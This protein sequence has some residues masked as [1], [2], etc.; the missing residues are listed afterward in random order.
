MGAG[1]WLEVCSSYQNI[2][3]FSPEL[4]FT[5]FVC[6]ILLIAGP[7]QDSNCDYVSKSDCKEALKE[8]VTK[9]YK[10]KLLPLPVSLSI[11]HSWVAHNC[12]FH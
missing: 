8:F 9:G 10:K 3:S 7:M 12:F 4:C 1:R 6:D 5:K 11:S 2:D